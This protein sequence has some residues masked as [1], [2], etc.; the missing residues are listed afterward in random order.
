MIYVPVVVKNLNKFKQI[1]M[2]KIKI[3]LA[4]LFFAAYGIAQNND[5]ILLKEVSV[6]A[7]FRPTEKTPITEKTI[8]FDDIQKS[9]FGQ[10]VPIFLSNTP[11][12]TS[13][14]DG[15]H[16]S[17]YTYM[18]LRGVDQTR[19]NFTLNGVPMNEPEDQG[20]YSS[21][22][23]DF[24]NSMNS[25]Q[26][27]RGVGI[28]TNG[29]SSYI[30][31]VNFES[32]NLRDSALTT[33]SGTYGS[34]NSYRGSVEL[35]TGL[36]DNGWA[37][38]NRYSM[39]GSSGYRDH[40]GGDG[41][42]FFFSA[43]Y[44]GFKKAILKINAFSG[45]SNNQM[46][47]MGSSK[48]EIKAFG[49][50]YNPNSAN[51]FDKFKQSFV[52]FQYTNILN[53]YSFITTTAYY[54]RL[55]GDWDLDPLN[56]SGDTSTN[57]VLNSQLWSNFTGLMT[58][59]R[60]NKNNV[61]FNAGVQANYYERSHA[62][63]DK[64]F[65]QDLFY[66]NKGTKNTASAF[67]KIEFDINKFTLFGDVEFRMTQFI[68]EPDEV[69]PI[70]VGL[71]SKKWL[72]LNPKAGIT[73]TLNS[74]MKVYA[75]IGQT[76]REFTRTDMF[77]GGDNLTYV[78]DTSGNRIGTNFIDTNKIDPELREI[79]TDLE[80]GFKFN[81]EYLNLQING[82]YMDFTDEM[83]PSGELGENGLPLMMTVKNS[84]RSGVELD[85]FYKV[86]N[87][88]FSNRSS[89]MYC[90][91]KDFETTPV[92][93]P[94]LVLHQS[95]EYSYKKV[96]IGVGFKYISER[97]INLEN[98]ESIPESKGFNV[99]LRYNYKMHDVT[100]GVRNVLKNDVKGALSYGNG[101]IDYGV[102]R[103]FVNAP[104]NFFVT[105]HFRF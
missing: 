65:S 14:A 104:R 36:L 6:I 88:T 97:Y 45:Y 34:F 98:T 40:S 60:Y 57:I 71:D 10:E 13:Y 58:N 66:L 68:Y 52:Q 28:T 50:R 39:M 84:F 5:T 102:P 95:V 85:A 47:W 18:R 16:F 83:V 103:Y 7:T 24:L 46:A 51:E 1:K 37:F 20:F 92:M 105:L 94:S 33:I 91:I 35:N 72:F 53:K 96:S 21:N 89:Y 93:T 48:S 22:F 54:N 70:S 2:K 42:S 87:F 67:T 9:S 81:N 32:A 79:A 17:G 15:G 31:S 77:S 73:L 90:L 12:I 59:Y 62:C 75:S 74:K 41:G 44:F 11:S 80:V 76:K 100:F 30:G 23:P 55:D 38:Y 99:S 8:S 63:A 19:I 69:D 4:F 101:Y 78:Y 26:I 25:I 49:I 43:G 27:Q 56:T 3:I 86:K 82:F 64:G 29:V 61:R